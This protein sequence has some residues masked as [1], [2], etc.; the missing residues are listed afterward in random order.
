[1][2]PGG[3]VAAS[4]ALR[5]AIDGARE[6]LDV[7]NPY[8]TDRDMIERILAAARRGVRVQLVVSE[9]SNNAQASAALEHRH[10]DLLEAGVEV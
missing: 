7:M 5:E 10:A 3:F 8:V 2:I 9:T 1:M 6:R 4:Q